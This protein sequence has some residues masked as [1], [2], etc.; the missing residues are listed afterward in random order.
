MM[1]KDSKPTATK[2]AAAKKPAPKLHS[3]KWTLEE[4]VYV[5]ALMEEFRA[6]TLDLQEGT[7]L[8][9]FL[10]L[11]LNCKPKRIS[12]KYEGK[13][14]DGK[15]LFWKSTEDFSPAELRM[16]RAKL[17]ALKAKFEECLEAIEIVKA[18]RQPY[19]AS[20][21]SRELQ[22][23]EADFLDQ[24]QR[25]AMLGA[26]PN[27]AGL[28]MGSLLFQG[29]SR[30]AAH[31][32]GM[33]GSHLPRSSAAPDVASM[34]MLLAR[35][36]RQLQAMEN[37]AAASNST[38]NQFF[39][40][41]AASLAPQ[42]PQV[43]VRLGSYLSARQDAALL[44]AAAAARQD[45]ALFEAA[46][47]FGSLTRPSSPFGGRNPPSPQITSVLGQQ[48]PYNQARLAM[49]VRGNSFTGSTGT[50]NPSSSMHSAGTAN[51]DLSQQQS[52][53]F[54]QAAFRPSLNTMLA[55]RL[56][57]RQTSGN[58]QAQSMYEENMLR[59][60]QP[61]RDLGTLR[62]QA[63]RRFSDSMEQKQT[64]DIVDANLKRSMGD[65]TGLQYLQQQQQ[66]QQEQQQK[67]QR[68]F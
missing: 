60:Q 17:A 59:F 51:H 58:R 13:N 40:S 26:V 54:P 19:P 9:S 4:E 67:R 45:A 63:A 12:K 2:T 15:Q 65:V 44:E 14:Y 39:R 23:K 55:S 49:A 62:E 3:G 66:Q 30:G 53:S 25:A 1:E 16:R 52:T 38:S 48:S 22:D 57:G 6:G 50:Y 56:G 34:D 20:A 42:Q 47:G 61:V 7:T 21:S 11:Q 68:F 10:A 18:S 29:A 64:E 36:Q 8:R 5:E 35:H 33:P 37:F 31:T 24:Q 43:P 27:N 46:A 28:S 41:N 32:H